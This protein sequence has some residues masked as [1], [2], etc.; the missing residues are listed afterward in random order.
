VARTARPQLEALEGRQLL[1]ASAVFGAAGN[2]FR[3]LVDN[4]GTLTETYLGRTATLATGVL[5]AH[6]Y[7]D[8]DGSIGITVVYQNFSAFDYDHTGG[9]Y[10]GGNIHDVDKA[11]DRAGHIQEDVTYELVANKFTTF[12]YTSTAAYQVAQGGFFTLLIRPFQDSQG[13]LGRGRHLRHPQQW[14][15][16]RHPD[17]VRLRRCSLRGARRG[18]RPGLRP[19]R[20][21]VRL[22]RHLLRLGRCRRVHEPLGDPPGY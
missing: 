9:H 11:F 16:Y 2:T 4:T 17:R 1:N 6:A 14:H 15:P 20:P 22:Q 21:A 8:S 13:N 12:E 7:R 18:G 3:L 10:L 19:R 5:R